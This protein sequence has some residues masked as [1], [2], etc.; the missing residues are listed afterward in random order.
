M[1]VDL[2]LWFAGLVM[3]VKS[4]VDKKSNT[5][6]LKNS[7]NDIDELSNSLNDVVDSLANLFGS[8]TSC[9]F[10]CNDGG[11]PKPRPGHKPS[12]NGCGSFGL[13][14]DTSTLPVMTKCCDAHDECYD[15]CN[16]DK[17]ECDKK[18]KKCLEKMCKKL[19]PDLNDDESVGCRATA[20]LMSSGTQ[21]LGCQAYL[22]SQKTA[23]ECKSSSGQE[24]TKSRKKTEL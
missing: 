12:S 21:A 6:N 18:F 11:K 13:E 10:R 4:A 2:F 1:N 14:L 7:G 15:T 3:T 17:L 24:K 5:F 23:C 20:M 16:K 8:D 9:K 22:D 19:E